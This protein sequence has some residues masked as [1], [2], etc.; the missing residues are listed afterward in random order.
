MSRAVLAWDRIVTAVL[1]LALVAV[2]MAA[3]LWWL[4]T[5]PGW[6]TELQSDQTLAWTTQPW[7]PWAVGAAGVVLILLGV[8]WLASHLPN[9]GVTHLKL[10]GSNRRGRLDAQVR[11]IAGAAADAFALTPGVRSARGSIEQDRG[12]LVARIRATVEQQA[13]LAAVAAA[14]D[15]VSADLRQVMQRDDV[16]SQIT[17]TVARSERALSRVE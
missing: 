1:G 16:V 11:P 14:A 4:G 9:R 12:Q 2:G 17:L 6:P 13:D 7:W 15:Q 10:P 8:R 3:A 5:F